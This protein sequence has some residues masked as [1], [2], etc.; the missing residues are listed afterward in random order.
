MTPYELTE[1]FLL[2]L[3]VWREARGA[4]REAKRGVVHV[5]L[6][7]AK[8]PKGPYVRCKDVLS[9]V[10]C[11]A[12]FSSFSA[13]DPNAARLP[14]PEQIVDWKA[15]LDTCAVADEPGDDPTGGANYYHTWP[16][17]STFWPAWAKPERQTAQIGPFRFYRL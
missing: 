12:Q 14:N 11:R 9:N 3:C 13:T 7:R 17:G 4:S 10:L 16:E 6:N 5:L 1:A 15:W 8:D 2:R